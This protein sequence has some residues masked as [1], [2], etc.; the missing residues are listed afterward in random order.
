MKIEITKETVITT[1]IP[2][3]EIEAYIR[4]RLRA[5]PEF[6]GVEAHRISISWNENYCTACLRK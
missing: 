6:Q 3:P 1:K 2:L 5:M 4:E